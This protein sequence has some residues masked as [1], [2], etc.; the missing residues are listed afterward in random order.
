MDADKKDSNA[1]IHNNLGL[2]FE[3]V[4]QQDKAREFYQ[5]A[6]AE[7]DNANPALYNLARLYYL[8]N[9]TRKATRLWKQ[10]LHK[11]S[12]SAFA[13]VIKGI[14]NINDFENKKFPVREKISNTDLNMSLE[15]YLKKWKVA[16]QQYFDLDVGRFGYIEFSNGISAVVENNRVRM[17]TASAQYTGSTSKLISIGVTEEEVF[18]AYGH[19]EKFVTTPQGRIINYYQNRIAFYFRDG[20]LYAWSIYI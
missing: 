3:L 2:A 5:T 10:Y 16:R 9:D 15:F 14:L 17:L 4:Q 1:G 11:D 6:I 8:D 20:V 7:T 19:P 18:N 13:N 12:N